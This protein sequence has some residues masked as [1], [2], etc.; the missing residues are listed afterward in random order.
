MRRSPRIAARIAAKRP[1]SLMDPTV[2]FE[3]SNS[4]DIIDM[5]QD[6]GRVKKRR[7]ISIVSKTLLV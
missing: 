2:E 5:P 4:Q 1:R 3:L 7:K 6:G